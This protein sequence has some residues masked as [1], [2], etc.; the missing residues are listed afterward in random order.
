MKPVEPREQVTTGAGGEPVG[1]EPDEES[2]SGPHSQPARRRSRLGLATQ[3]L[4]ARYWGAVLAALP[5]AGLIGGL[6][7]K[8]FDR[9][10]AEG[11]TATIIQRHTEQIATLDRRQTAEETVRL[12][13]DQQLQ[14][15]LAKQEGA[16]EAIQTALRFIS[17]DIADIKRTLELRRGA[18][19]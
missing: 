7:T 6:L 18:A 14:A 11:A 12:S 4:V 9:G 1:P 15:G 19:K 8:A 5:V 13:T 16:S 3:D 17:S 2:G 10:L